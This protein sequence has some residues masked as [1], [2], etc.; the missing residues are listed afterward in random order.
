MASSVMS[1]SP[2]AGRLAAAERHFNFHARKN[3]TQSDDS[4]PDWSIE[5]LFRRFNDR[6]DASQAYPWSRNDASG[7]FRR[8]G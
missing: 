8:C 4:A 5:I 6:D 3:G 1:S 2:F 7:S